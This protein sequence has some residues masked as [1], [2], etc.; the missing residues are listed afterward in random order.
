MNIAR[1]AA[2]E[3]HL[4]ER[5]LGNE[6]LAAASSRPESKTESKVGI[7]SRHV[8]A[9]GEL[10]SDLAFKA[11]TALFAR[12][13]HMR[14]TVDYVLLCTQSPDHVL[15]TTACILQDRLGLPTTTGALDFN[16]G[17]SG[18]VVGLGL[19]KGLIETGQASCV[20]LLTAETYT[21]F[22]RD[23]DY[24]LRLLF[25]DAAAA[26]LV[27][28]DEAFE[29]S[30][31][32]FVYGTDGRGAQKLTVRG[33]G[34]RRDEHASEA[35]PDGW[36]YMDGPSIFTFTLEAIPEAVKA[37]LAKAQL[38]AADI[39]MYVFHQANA[40]M[41]EHLRKKMSIAPERFAVQM[42]DCGNTVSSTIPIA[43]AQLQREGRVKPGMRLMLVGFGVG[44]SW[45]ACIVNL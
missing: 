26:T 42:A 30:I 12:Y 29:E 35:S 37:L 25:G 44:L 36:L 22:I 17:C 20:L 45:A 23:E 27:T 4:P 34:L 41:L 31:G 13:P 21:K 28:A 11:A 8:A 38:D 19:A 7:S 43:L 33:S 15:P 1:I 6:E 14:E 5:K 10:S 32:P 24:A 16:L 40:Y 39:D 2:I 3:Y 18:Y 9:E